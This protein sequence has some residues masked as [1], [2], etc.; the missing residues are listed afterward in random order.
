MSY[1]FQ[2]VAQGADR[3]GMSADT[4]R[5][6]NARQWFRAAAGTVK[7]V[8]ANALMSGDPNRLKRRLFNTDI[9]KMYLFFYDPLHK[10]TLPYYDSFPMI[11]V[12]DFWKGAK[13]SGFIGINLHYL[14][15]PLRAKLMDA[16]WT[17][18]TDK[19]YDDATKLRI[20]YNI[21]K[22]ASKYKWFYP[23]I[24]KYIWGHCRSRFYRVPATEWDLALML[25]LARFTKAS[26]IKV[27][28]DSSKKIRKKYGSTG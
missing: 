9:G 16:L 7:R 19:R 21:L 1:I 12:I 8:D 14:A 11:F 27:W 13:N 18:A 20:S 15:P 22:N 6:R 28:A 23:C 2:T 17:T 10:K 24:K 3:S 5:L 4:L 26:P 25:P